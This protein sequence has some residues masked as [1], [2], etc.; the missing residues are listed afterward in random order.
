MT[1]EPKIPM[2]PAELPQQ[3]IHEVIT[4]PPK[5]EPFDCT[6]GYN[7][8]GSLPKNTNANSTYLCQVEWAWSPMHNRLDAYYIHRGRSDW[9]LWN[10]YW[11]DNWG[12]WGKVSIG[13]VQRRGVDQN[14][15]AIYLL[16]E[17]WKFDAKEGGLD[18]FHWINET[19]YL[20]VAELDAIA[21][22][23]WAD[24]EN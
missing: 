14:Q 24:T 16:M 6:V 13:M 8:V 18:K 11:D 20:D 7:D 17:Y 22:E 5:P 19:E 3:R 10:K 23:V 15:A 2:S 9:I 4:M 21:N 12:R 1:R